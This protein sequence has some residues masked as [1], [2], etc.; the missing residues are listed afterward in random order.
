[1]F[2]F[3][4]STAKRQL[5]IMKYLVRA[6]CLMVRRFLTATTAAPLF[7]DFMSSSSSLV[8]FCSGNTVTLATKSAIKERFSR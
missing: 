4:C 7:S 6:S 8:Y 1:M 2:Y 5:F 3:H